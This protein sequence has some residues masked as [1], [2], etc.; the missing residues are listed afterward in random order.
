MNNL[1]P[2]NEITTIKESMR[3]DGIQ[4]VVVGGVI[5]RDNSIL[6]LRRVPDDFMGGLI[7]LPSGGVDQDED[8][9][10][11]LVR[12]VK[13]E[14][15]LSVSS[16]ESY[17]GSFDYISGSGKKTRQLNFTITCN[18]SVRLSLSE[19]DRYFWLAPGSEEYSELNISKQTKEIL[20]KVVF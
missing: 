15:G 11:A 6:L 2:N 16:I 1:I 14:T 17:V 9:I 12:E 8:I 19:H 3:S 20:E 7:E 4:K 10:E 5:H 18:G 13:E